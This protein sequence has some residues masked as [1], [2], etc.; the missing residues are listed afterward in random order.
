[1]QHVVEPSVANLQGCFS[2]ERPPILT[3]ESGDTLVCR[4]LDA[5][6]GLD[7]FAVDGDV[8]RTAIPV[9][10]RADPQHDRG[11]CLIGPIAIQGAQ[12][13][14]ALEVELVSIAPAPLGSTWVGEVREF[15][16]RLGVDGYYFVPWRIDT[17]QRVARDPAGHSIALRPFLGVVGVAPAE[18]GYHSTR[19]PG[20]WGGNLDCKELIAGSRLFLPIQVP[21]ALLSFGD[22]HAAQGDG[23]VGGTAIECAMDSVEL[24][25]RL[26]GN[27]HI[28]WP[29]AHTPQ[30]WLTFG[31]HTDLTEATLIALNQMLDLMMDR[32]DLARAEALALASLVVD[33]RVTQIANGVLGA[34]ALL[35]H[36]AL[37]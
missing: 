36:D 19:M 24:C 17:A 3:I 13:G 26:R 21:G 31:T 1:M 12:P 9:E 33:L 15:L 11:H 27:M 34:H 16:P 37:R 25:V 14:M 5:G 23:E 32:F 22:G 35:P 30:G 29:R 8:V 10:R 6:W 7:P 18:P 4:T 28:E 20:A 2:R